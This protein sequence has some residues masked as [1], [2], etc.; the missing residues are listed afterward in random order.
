MCFIT[1]DSLAPDYPIE[2]AV[3]PFA[4]IGLEQDEIEDAV[5]VVEGKFDLMEAKA[6]IEQFI[7]D[8]KEV[9]RTPEFYSEDFDGSRVQLKQTIKR[10]ENLI[11]R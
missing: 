10:A 4:L 9:M 11:Q 5:R 2:L 6:V 8:C 1:M 7:A 3:N